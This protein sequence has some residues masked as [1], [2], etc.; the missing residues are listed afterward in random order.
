MRKSGSPKVMWRAP[1]ST[2]LRDVGE[3][4]VCADDADA[5]VVDG[6]HRAVPAAVHAAVARLDVADEPLVAAEREVR[7]ALERRQQVARRQLELAAAE[8]D[9]RLVGPRVGRTAGRQLADPRRQRRLVLAGDHAV[10]QRADGE[11]AADRRVEAVEADRQLGARAARRRPPPASRGASRCASA[12]R[13]RRPAA[14]SSAP[15]SQGSTDRSRQR[16]S[17]P[18]LRSAA[19]G[20]ATCSG[21]WPS[22]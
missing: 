18:A 9:E 12:P 16:T 21:W 8:L 11:V 6:R 17:C 15:A 10:G 19:A 4:G 13:I 14:H 3:H 2:R 7:V 20:E 5:P 22:S 1:S